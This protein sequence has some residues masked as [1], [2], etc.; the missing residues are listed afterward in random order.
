MIILSG[1][2]LIPLFPQ[3]VFRITHISLHKINL[4]IPIGPNQR[5]I[6]QIKQPNLLLNDLMLMLILFNIQMRRE[7]IRPY[8][9]KKTI[10]GAFK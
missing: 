8:L 10:I 4:P 1:K 9:I 2:Y 6:P 7:L 5:A 3:R